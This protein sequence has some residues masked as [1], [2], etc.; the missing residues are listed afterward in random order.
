M[1]LGL[2]LAWNYRA[3]L[4]DPNGVLLADSGDGMKNYFT[5]A[6]HAHHDHDALHFGGSG[7]P[8]GDHAFY[9]DCHPLLA[10][11]IQAVPALDPWK[12]GI[13]NALL[14]LGRIICAWCL[15]GLM[16]HFRMPPWPAAACAFGVALLEPQALRMTGHLA[17]AH[18]WVVPLMWYTWVRTRAKR[19]MGALLLCAGAVLT[20]FLIHPYLG[21]M[22]AM[23][24]FAYQAMAFL[25]KGTRTPLPIAL[26][27]LFVTV[28]L[29]VL[30]F[31]VIER[32]ADHTCDRPSEQFGQERYAVRWQSL[33]VPLDPP[34]GPHLSRLVSWDEVDWESWSYLGMSSVIALV[35]LLVLFLGRRLRKSVDWSAENSVTLIAGLIVLLFAMNVWQPLLSGAF[36]SLLQFRAMGRFA[37]VFFYVSAVIG[38]STVYL[39]LVRPGRLRPWLASA[40]FILFA[41]GYTV[42]GWVRQRR[43]AASLP[44][45]P[46]P[47]I[48]DTRDAGRAE[49]LVALSRSGAV[50]IIPLPYT[51]VGSDLYQRDA[52]EQVLSAMYP[53]SYQSGLP[54]MAGNMIR[55]SASHTRELITV[56]SPAEF[57]KSLARRFPPDTRF[58]L[59]STGAPMDTDEERIWNLGDSL[60]DDG[61]LRLRTILAADL[62]KSTQEERLRHFDSCKDSMVWR[63]DWWLEESLDRP[64]SS[65]EDVVAW[66]AEK[67][68][69]G[70][71]GRL[72]TIS[73]LPVGVLDPLRTYE[74]CMLFESI[75]PIAVNTSLLIESVQPSGDV[76]WEANTNMRCMTMQAGRF[77]VGTVRFRPKRAGLPYH[78]F[79]T[80][81]DG[82]KARFVVRHLLI[83]PIEVDAWRKGP[84]FGEEVL[85][86]NG[87]PL[88]SHPDEGGLGCSASSQQANGVDAQ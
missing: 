84:W 45:V 7:F 23:F 68:I 5:Y 79:M 18:A 40:L 19:T 81:P 30:L 87:I 2:F 4:I 1:A 42:E 46:N 10:W 39:F 34:F 51:H 62:F 28:G 25:A 32:A 37:W 76:E 70:E 50:A 55:T 49:H 64:G 13:V 72:T 85:F 33:L 3:V 63:E 22:G 57:H 35:L 15:F 61:S 71:S 21:L 56:L 41:G 75:D 59:M 6:W 47:F 26:R 86:W 69:T 52:P 11:L 38:S 8:Y 60:Y 65:S 43:L 74:L 29:P 24:L 31:L 78:V 54:L 9:T 17:L 53:L 58:A 48:G 14:V 36:G 82:S 12:I 66:D 83:R 16:R 88:A 20:A 77:T 73:R 44:L 27:D 80:G 67:R